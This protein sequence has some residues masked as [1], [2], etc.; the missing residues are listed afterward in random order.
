MSLVE[1]N[2]CHI[3]SKCLVL[4][5]FKILSRKSFFFFTY[6]PSMNRLS[7][8][9]F[10]SIYMVL[11]FHPWCH[12]WCLEINLSL[13]CV[14]KFILS[15][16]FFVTAKKQ[17]IGGGEFALLRKNKGCYF[18]PLALYSIFLCAWQYR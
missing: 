6:H 16:F 5:M 13:S 3:W 18:S 17:H 12:L 4:F 10:P 8:V 11:S 15:H 7:P 14:L 1:T 2:S 9:L